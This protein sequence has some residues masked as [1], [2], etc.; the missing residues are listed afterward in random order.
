VGG[1]APVEMW[2]YDGL[3]PGPVIR[4]RRGDRLVV[5]FHNGLPA[6]TTIHWHGLRVPAAMDGSHLTQGP[7]PSGGT[8][9][10]AFDLPDAGT[11][12]YHPHHL[13][14]H[15]V[16]F[17]LYAPLVV[18]EPDEPAGLGRD[19]VL[20]LSDVSLTGAGNGLAPGDEGGAER[21]R[22]GREGALVLVNG[23]HLPTVRVAA[24]ERQRWR[25]INAARSRF[26]R[27]QLEGHRLTRIGGDGGLLEAPQPPV[28]DLLLAPG[29]RAEVVVALAAAAGARVPLLLVPYDRGGDSPPGGPAAASSPIMFLETTAAA[30]SDGA[31]PLPARLRTIERLAPAVDAPRQVIRIGERPDGFVINERPFGGNE[32]LRAR[33]GETHLF[34]VTNHTRFDHPF[35]LH[36]FFF[37]VLDPQTVVPAEPA[38]WKDTVNVTA[39]GATALAVRFDDRPGPWMFHCHIL[40]HA[41]LGLM[42]VLDLTR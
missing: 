38:E 30:A 34:S 33:V 28:D 16:G 25:L 19:A 14:H 37:Q 10:Y 27:L 39:L 24:G 5:H 2:T 17:G 20:V 8:F 42:G 31:P 9:E 12:W 3:L 23:R 32:P 26:F 18:D 41:E 22:Q 4:A 21:A 15:Q 40:D 36:G 35:H 29:E 6:P 7:T 13:S 11:F 1:A